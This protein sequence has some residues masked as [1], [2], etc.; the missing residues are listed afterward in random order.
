VPDLDAAVQLQ[1]GN[2][3]GR[4]IVGPNN[5]RRDAPPVVTQ[6]AV[7]FQTDQLADAGMKQ[8]DAAIAVQ[9]EHAVDVDQEQRPSRGTS[10]GRRTSGW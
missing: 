1:G 10:P 4:W 2:A 6:G 5:P 9:R 3:T 8:V 7:V